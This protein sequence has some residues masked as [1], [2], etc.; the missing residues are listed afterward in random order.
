VS[1][2]AALAALSRHEEAEAAITAMTR[3]FRRRRD[4][5]LET[6]AAYPRIRYVHPEGAFYIYINVGD[7]TPGDDPGGTFSARVLEEQQVAVVPGSAF[8]T[9]EWIRASYATSL[10]IAVDGISRIARCLTT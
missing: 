10:D 1:Q 7:W 8:L 9:P 6:L 5:V 3:E 4:A 2:H